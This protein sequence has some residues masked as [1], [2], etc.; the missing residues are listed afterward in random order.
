[1][2]ESGGAVACGFGVREGGGERGPGG[3]V[4]NL[5]GIGGDGLAY[6]LGMA[7]GSWLGWATLG[8]SG[9]GRDCGLV[10]DGLEIGECAAGGLDLLIV[11]AGGLP[12]LN[13]HEG[14]DGRVEEHRDG[15]F[16]AARWLA[17]D[18]V[19]SAAEG[20]GVVVVGLDAGAAGAFE[21]EG[22]LAELGS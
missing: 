19:D 21:V 12:A 15:R 16:V 7:F 14:E 20:S 10:V 9:Q 8:E 6:A 3:V 17:G 5:I 2:E 1:M 18:G 4:E 11:V 22:C 13:C